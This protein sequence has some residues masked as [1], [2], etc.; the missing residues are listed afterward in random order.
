ME[1]G[2]GAHTRPGWAG[3]QGAASSSCAYVVACS[4]LLIMHVLLLLL[5]APLSAAGQA[6]GHELGRVRRGQ[7]LLWS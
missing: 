7:C 5:H 3:G 2:Q 1:R 4:M 6:K